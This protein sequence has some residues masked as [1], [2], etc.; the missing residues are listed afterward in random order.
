MG[1]KTGVYMVKCGMVA[2]LLASA[3]PA[4]AQERTVDLGDI[5]TVAGL[6]LQ[7]GYKAELKK[8]K[9]G[10]TYIASASNGNEFTVNFYN[11]T[12]DT[13][14]GSLEFSSWYKKQPYFSAEMANEWNA[15]KRFLKIAVDGD[16]DLVEYVYV[17]TIGR[18]TFK[19]FADYIDW[20]TQMDGSLSTF[21]REKE[22]A[23]KANTAPPAK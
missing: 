20:F 16:G 17:S 5:K 1:T 4:S 9:N 22:E 12:K 7:A 6:L 2:M 3:M 19:N 15:K 21:L 8:A 10:D 11:C 13:G 18:S 14:C 23:A